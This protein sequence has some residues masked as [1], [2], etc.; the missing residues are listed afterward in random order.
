MT[1]AGRHFKKSGT[2]KKNNKTEFRLHIEFM[3]TEVLTEVPA[4]SNFTSSS[5]EIDNGAVGKAFLIVGLAAIFSILG[6]WLPLLDRFNLC[7]FKFSKSPAFLAASISLAAGVLAYL[8][9]TDVISDGI[10]AISSSSNEVVVQHSTVIG[11]L[12][13]IYVG[14]IGRLLT[15]KLRSRGGASARKALSEI[16]GVQRHS[17]QD[18]ALVVQISDQECPPALPE[19]TH[20]PNLSNSAALETG[21]D[22]SIEEGGRALQRDAWL[23]AIALAARRASS[24]SSPPTPRRRLEPPSLL[25]SSS[26]KS[27]AVAPRPF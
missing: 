25:A 18:P 1:Y 7:E 27:P 26:T 12:S 9:L 23:L 16:N 10:E 14:M 17:L 19:N 2:A 13:V 21:S 8:S 15:R 4:V 22:E 5:G 3:S 11:N 6:A 20:S 24:S